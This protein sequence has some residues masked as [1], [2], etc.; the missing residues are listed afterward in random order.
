MKKRT[1]G[2]ARRL[3]GVLLMALV[4]I[5]PTAALSCLGGCPGF[6]LGVEVERDG[7]SIGGEC[8]KNLD[9]TWSCNV[10]AHLDGT[11]AHEETP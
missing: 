10:K 9:G 7:K 6:G 11:A 3:A 8:H 4:L 2:R 5:V 1:R